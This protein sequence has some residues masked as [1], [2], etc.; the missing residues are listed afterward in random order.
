[1][2]ETEFL[3]KVFETY[4][5]FTSPISKWS[6]DAYIRI[7][8]KNI[9]LLPGNIAL[10]MGC[11]DGYSTSI[12]SDLVERLDVVD[13]SKRMLEKLED[14]VVKKENVTFIYSLF[15]DLVY[16]NK[17]DNIFCSYVLEH[18]VDP[19][20]ILEIAYRAL[21]P[22]GRLFITVPNGQALSRQMALDMGLLTDLYEL[23]ENDLAHGH[24]RVFDLPQ[25]QNLI[26]KSSFKLLEKGG[27]FVKEFADFQLNKM[28][29]NEIIGKDQLY[30][31]EKLAERYPG[32]SGSIY[33]ICEKP[34][35]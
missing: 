2:K 6:T 11:S 21:K 18:V 14:E 8:L 20:Q 31:M 26:E 7:Y 15:E 32:L 22:G 4:K 30:G 16:E 28:I 27:T 25:L 33:A 3:D 34:K 19:F 13:G 29:E 1:M 10:E 17:Y 12:L 24:R 23:T 35:N 9:E 5:T